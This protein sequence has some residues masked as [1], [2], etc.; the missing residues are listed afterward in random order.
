MGKVFDF[1]KARAEICKAVEVDSPVAYY[2]GL[3]ASIDTIIH[4]IRVRVDPR[5][6]VGEIWAVDPNTGEKLA[7]LIL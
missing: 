7:E 5:V 1:E 3:V 2:P 4:G 6:P